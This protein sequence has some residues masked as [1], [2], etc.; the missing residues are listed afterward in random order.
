MSPAESPTIQAPEF[1]AALAKR[2]TAVYSTPDVVEQRRQTLTVLALEPGERVIDIGGAPGYLARDIAP[3]VGT[4]GHVI[5]VDN[6]DSML[7]AARETCAGEPSIDVMKGDASHLPAED[8]EFDVAVATQVFEFVP[9]VDAALAEAFRV[10]RPGGRIVVLD[11]DSDSIVWASSDAALTTELLSAWD[12]R[13]ADPHLPRSLSIRLQRA[14]FE[15]DRIAVIPIVNTTYD[16]ATLSFH[17]SKQIAEH[18]VKASA[19][20]AEHAERWLTDLTERQLSGLYFFSL[21]R[22]VFSAHRP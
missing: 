22:Y 3:L 1:D 18:A 5:V 7:Q 21:N 16:P 14:G 17:L 13:H 15:I 2:L 10:L 8:A 9:D 6:S 12:Q 20:S 19:V 11:T 4:D